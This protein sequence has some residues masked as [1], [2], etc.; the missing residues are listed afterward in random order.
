MYTRS[1][2]EAHE[3][4]IHEDRKVASMLTDDERSCAKITSE[5]NKPHRRHVTRHVTSYHPAPTV[6]IDISLEY[7][8]QRKPH[9]LK[10]MFSFIII[11]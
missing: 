7:T 5:T 4:L 2:P 6:A 1:H 9:Q 11:T 8:S 3:P 10:Q